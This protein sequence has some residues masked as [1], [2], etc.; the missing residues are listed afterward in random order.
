[1]SANGK[2]KNPIVTE[3]SPVSKFYKAEKYHQEYFKKNGL[4]SCHIVK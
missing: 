3:I 2:W 4:P 1:M